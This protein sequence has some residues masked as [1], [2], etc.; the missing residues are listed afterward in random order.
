MER[1][2]PILVI[3]NDQSELSR[4]LIRAIDAHEAV[5]VEACQ[6]GLPDI[7]SEIFKMK[8]MAVLIIPENYSQKIKQGMQA[9][10]SLIANN[11]RFMVA[12]DVLRGV[13]DV[14]SEIS[15]NNVM[16][17]YRTKG[18]N[19]TRAVSLANPIQFDI[20]CLFNTTEAYGDFIIVGLL[21]LIFQQTLVIAAAVSIANERETNSI[22]LLFHKASG[23]FIKI[24]AGKGILYFIVFSI[25]TFFFFN[26]H[27]LIYK[28]P[29]NGSMLLL[30][31]VTQIQIIVLFLLGGII[32]TFFRQKL[33]ALI[34]LAFMSYPVF[35]LSGYSWP[36]T[37]FPEPIKLL[38]C[39]L[40][41]TWYFNTYVS[42]AQEGGGIHNVFSYIVN[43]VCI[44]C[45]LAF[46]LWLRM[47][48]LQ[49][50]TIA[51]QGV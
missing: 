43:I 47:M 21:A 15:K 30:I 12:N 9:K 4:S 50:N 38:S 45:I 28:I 29:F 20:R 22:G 42:I 14:I 5:A 46:V 32:G 26:F 13:N 17:Y 41:Q 37:A 2:V 35:L 10:I 16:Q 7:E 1:N 48:S 23:S 39:I 49:K 51:K 33:F 31:L 6:K 44:G 18:M 8:Y 36:Y 40:P 19:T 11:G 24:V 34:F 27:F 25:Y 3:D